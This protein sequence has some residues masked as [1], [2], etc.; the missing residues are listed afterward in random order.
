MNIIFCPI[1]ISNSIYCKIPIKKQFFLVNRTLII[2]KFTTNFLGNFDTAKT[3]V[4]NSNS[5]KSFA[6]QYQKVLI[7]S[8]LIA[9]NHAHIYMNFQ[10]KVKL[11]IQFDTRFILFICTNTYFICIYYIITLLLTVKVIIF[12]NLFDASIFFFT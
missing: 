3:K 11:N 9:V 12:P 6:L 5:K 10:Q 7:W 4:E 2:M 1:H 8:K